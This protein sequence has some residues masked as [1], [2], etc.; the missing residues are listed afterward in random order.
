MEKF[1]RGERRFQTER[2]KKKRKNYWGYPIKRYTYQAKPM[3]AGRLGK[4]VQYP[5]WCSCSKC[6]GS[7]YRR[8][9]GNGRDGLTFQELRHLD[10]EYKLQE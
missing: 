10:A 5:A 4:V 9:R 1:H 6:S 8:I 2:L 3:N 7:T